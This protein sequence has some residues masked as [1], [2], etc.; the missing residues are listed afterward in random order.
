MVSSVVASTA[1]VVRLMGGGTVLLA[2][3]VALPMLD[4]RLP[5]PTQKA[6]ASPA[7]SPTTAPCGGERHS[8][9]WW[10]P[11][12]SCGGGRRGPGYSP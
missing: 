6:M 5:M 8:A 10:H 4:T 3:G 11:R 12:G 9:P 1:G 2:R 7:S